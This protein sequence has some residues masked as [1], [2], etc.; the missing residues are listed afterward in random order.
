MGTLRDALADIVEAIGGVG[1][2]NIE[3]ATD[4]SL[5]I[6]GWRP[7][8]VQA[9]PDAVFVCRGHVTVI[10]KLGVAPVHHLAGETVG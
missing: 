2:E 4:N 5:A 9:R 7:R 1:V 6:L 8:E 3:A 10:G